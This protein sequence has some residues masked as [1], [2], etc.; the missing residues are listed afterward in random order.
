MVI[1]VNHYTRPGFKAW[2]IALTVSASI[3]FDIHWVVTAGW[4]YDDILRSHTVTPISRWLLRRITKSYGFTSM[5]A[6]PPKPVQTQARATAVRKLLRYVD[7]TDQPIIGLAP[8]G[9]DSPS[10]Q[11][12]P[13][14]AGAGR[15]LALLS[16]R[17]LAWLPMGIYEA[18]GALHVKF[19]SVIDAAISQVQHTDLDRKMAEKAMSAI[20]TCLPERLRGPYA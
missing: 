20:A 6:M 13:P 2:W 1:L 14:P 3:S 15:L 5:P 9:A 19:G 8:E 17:G 10:G 18:D 7:T 4:V 12:Q 16:K 11:L